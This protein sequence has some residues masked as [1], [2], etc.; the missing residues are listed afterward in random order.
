MDMIEP[1]SRSPNLINAN[2]CFII[3]IDVQ[4]TFMQGLTKEE[5]LIFIRKY[6]H[7]IKLSYVLTIPLLV[8]AEDIQKN[9]S[10]PEN[11]QTL[12]NEKIL[13]LDKF[14]YSCWGQKNIQRAIRNTQRKVA[15]ICGFE[16][17]VC[18]AQTGLDLLDNGYKVVILEDITFSRN[19][20]EHE[21]GL[22]RLEGQGA[23][24]SGLKSWQEEITAGT[25]TKINQILTENG[26]SN[27]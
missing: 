1:L 23:I 19:K 27:V 20:I 13:V 10:I 16:T 3:I 22:K 5:Q 6:N 15:V 26:L 8:T 11:L 12:L 7:L 4:S 24:V 14:V 25:R 9:G 21:I 18:I 17:D 2:D